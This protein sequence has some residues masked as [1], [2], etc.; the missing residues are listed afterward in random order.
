MF[1]EQR[2]H[3]RFVGVHSNNAEHVIAVQYQDG[4]WQE[5]TLSFFGLLNIDMSW[6]IMLN[7]AQSQGYLRTGLDYWK[8]VKLETW[9]SLP[10]RVATRPGRASEL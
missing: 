9:S 1:S 8:D 5:A 7:T 4:Q 10:S 6:G 3:D 2:L